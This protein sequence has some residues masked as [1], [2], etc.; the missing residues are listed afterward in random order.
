MWCAISLPGE[1]IKLARFERLREDTV[2]QW[3]PSGLQRRCGRKG[4][5]RRQQIAS[6]SRAFL[7][8]LD[9]DLLGDGP[10]KQVKVGEVASAI[11]TFYGDYRNATVCWAEAIAF[12]V[13]AVNGDAVT[14][15]ELN[16]TR[17]RSA[18]SGCR[19]K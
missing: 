14:D 16:D 18:K 8:K 1:C 11:S 15:Q 19:G 10:N 6:P 12:S 17:A 3:I 9:R 7:E 4:V 13:M 5:T 2:C